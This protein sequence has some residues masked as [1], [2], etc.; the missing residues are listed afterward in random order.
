MLLLDRSP[1]IEGYLQLKTPFLMPKLEASISDTRFD[2]FLFRTE[3]FKLLTMTRIQELGMFIAERYNMPISIQKVSFY[4]N[5]I[6]MF[7]WNLELVKYALMNALHDNDEFPDFVLPEN[8]KDVIEK[9]IIQYEPFKE[10]IDIMQGSFEHLINNIDYE[11]VK[12]NPYIP[13]TEVLDIE[14]YKDVGTLLWVYHYVWSLVDTSEFED[15]MMSLGESEKGTDEFDDVILLRRGKKIALFNYNMSKKWNFYDLE[16]RNEREIKLR[17]DYEYKNID[18]MTFFDVIDDKFV[19]LDDILPQVIFYDEK[20]KRYK[21][22]ELQVDSMYFM[23]TSFNVKDPSKTNGFTVTYKPTTGCV[24]KVNELKIQDGK[25]TNQ[26][27]I[28]SN[29]YKFK[30]ANKEKKLPFK[31]FYN[32]Q[33]LD[34]GNLPWLK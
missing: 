6:R 34:A 4:Q 11:F 27:K 16:Y 1:N 30:I 22:D 5:M 33:K 2:S 20:G 18:Q 32:T 31:F 8:T 23:E 17:G 24:F 29:L 21:M 7:G 3:P 25:A 14:K 19:M 15:R 12:E 26:I 28:T 13:G 9:Y 10:S